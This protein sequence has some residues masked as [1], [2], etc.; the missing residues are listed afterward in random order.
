MS[1]ELDCA[2]AVYE[3]WGDLAMEQAPQACTD[4]IIALEAEVAALRDTSNDWQSRYNKALV[5]IDAAEYQL[6]EAEKVIA[7][8]AAVD[9][10]S[11]SWRRK[12]L[13]AVIV[14]ECELKD[15]P[16]YDHYAAARAFMEKAK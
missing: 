2:R 8:F 16:S 12:N 13:R 5:D 10:Q 9:F 7:P 15:S 6:A 3:A 1:S 11:A 4:Y 14:V